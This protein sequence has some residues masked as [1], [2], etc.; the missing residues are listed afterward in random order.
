VPL[1]RFYARF[2][3]PLP[4]KRYHIG[5]VYRYEDPQKGR[6]R[7]FYQCDADIIGAKEPFADIE[8]IDMMADIFDE[9]KIPEY[10]IK[11]NDRRILKGI[12][13]EKLNLDNKLM[14]KVFRIIDKLDKIGKEG[15]INELK[16]TGLSE[17]KINYISEI[18]ETSNYKN[19]EVLEF[20]KKFE[21][22]EVEKGV[23]LLEA[24]MDYSKARDRI[25][26]D[27][28]LVRGLDYY[29][30]MIYEIVVE[31]PR[32]GSL[33]GGGRYDNLIGM[34]AR[35]QVPAVGG[36]IGVERLIDAGLETGIFKIEKHTIVDA[37]VIPLSENVM[38]YAWEVASQLRKNNVNTSILY[39]PT[40][41]VKGIKRLEKRKIKYA[42]LIGEK[43]ASVKLVTLQNLET[44][45][46][47]EYRFEELSKAAKKILS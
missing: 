6:Y 19:E 11:L 32:I 16:N 2:R 47:E 45:E 27:L 30:G 13:E 46:R 4:F 9:F 12:F 1:A 14:L 22:K 36:S 38:K 39:E 18:L 44:R 25:K 41:P 5:K 17:N 42:V 40:S 31:K 26:I 23:K 29:T 21:N 8:I 35:E 37:G 7:E 15:V 24:F 43:E 33:S 20:L 34:F 3:P 10:T 28:S